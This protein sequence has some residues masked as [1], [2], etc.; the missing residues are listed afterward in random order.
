M[1]ERSL[2]CT[3]TSPSLADPER[4]LGGSG[5]WRKKHGACK[6]GAMQPARIAAVFVAVVLSTALHAQ[7]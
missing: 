6:D 3:C 5:Q 1:P 2:G 7:T 4:R